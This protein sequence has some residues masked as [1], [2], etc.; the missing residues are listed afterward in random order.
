VE[1]F[2]DP[3]LASQL[4]RLVRSA[5]G[6]RWVP[7]R[8]QRR[9][10]SPARGLP[11]GSFT[12]ELTFD[13]PEPTEA[14]RIAATEPSETPAPGAVP[15]AP[16]QRSPTPGAAA[17]KRVGP[18][19]L[20]VLC[21]PEPDGVKLAWGADEQFLARVLAPVTPKTAPSTLA[22]RAGL[23]A[24]NQQRTLAGGFFSL[25]AL[26]GTSS[27]VLPGF[28]PLPGFAL[29]ADILAP[30]RPGPPLARAALQAVEAAPHRGESPILYQLSRGTEQ[31]ALTLNAS[32]GRDTWEDLLFLIARKAPQP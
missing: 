2:A 18:P 21:V 22:A 17:Q 28:A 1:A 25:A 31:T 16:G 32:F 5:G 3:V 8:I 20:F 19:T 9:A 10:P 26:T 13:E 7:R 27:T 12:L 24:L 30:E 14:G 23:G 29:L 4:S 6:E 11:R 15:L